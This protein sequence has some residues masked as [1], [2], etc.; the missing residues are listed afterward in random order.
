M[1]LVIFFSLCVEKKK[2]QTKNSLDINIATARQTPKITIIE[3]SLENTILL[4]A[5][6]HHENIFLL[7]LPL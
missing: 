6:S 4:F 2:L 5:I 1:C 7:L 3:L